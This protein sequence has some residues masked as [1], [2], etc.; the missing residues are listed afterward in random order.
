MSEYVHGIQRGWLTGFCRASKYLMIATLI[1]NILLFLLLW[2]LI[3]IFL[4]F[5]SLGRQDFLNLGEELTFL[6]LNPQMQ[7]IMLGSMISYLLWLYAVFG[8]MVP[9]LR[10]LE[11]QG[12]S[13]GNSLNIVIVG[14]IA[15]LILTAV[16]ITILSLVYLI[17]S[18]VIALLIIYLLAFSILITYVL[19]YIGFFLVFDKLGHLLG[20]RRLVTAGVLVLISAFIIF[21]GPIAWFISFMTARKLLISTTV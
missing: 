18:N 5:F 8:E 16:Q 7:L 6:T 4:G 10:E 12:I 20:V 2:W 17:L 13:L 9:S 19:T 1:K 21:L 3:G 15:T 14:A 11:S